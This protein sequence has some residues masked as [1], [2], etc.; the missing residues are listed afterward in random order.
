MRNVTIEAVLNGFIVSVGCQR[1]VFTGLSDMLTEL[2]RY[3]IN[4]RETEQHYLEHSC[5]AHLVEANFA[6]IPAGEPAAPMQRPYF[7]V[8]SSVAGGSRAPSLTPR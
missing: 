5:N 4:P 3:C 2:R 8:G 1:V 7:E 6:T